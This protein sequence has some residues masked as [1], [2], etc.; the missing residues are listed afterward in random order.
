MSFNKWCRQDKQNMWNFCDS[1]HITRSLRIKFEQLVNGL[2][3]YKYKGRMCSMLSFSFLPCSYPQPHPSKTAL[4]RLNA[5]G[6][7]IASNFLFRFVNPIHMRTG[8]LHFY[9]RIVLAT[10]QFSIESI[11][12]SWS[13]TTIS[14]RVSLQYKAVM[15]L[16]RW[17]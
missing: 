12:N 9:C 14:F 1:I 16:N 6:C 4:I 8:T 10:R 13:S 3:W 11:G 5:D 7:H 2:H 17:N 15:I